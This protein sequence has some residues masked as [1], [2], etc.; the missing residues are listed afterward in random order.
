[1]SSPLAI[2]LPGQSMSFDWALETPPVDLADSL[3]LGLHLQLIAARA[4]SSD[5]SLCI[6]F[7]ARP[8]LEV[9]T[10]ETLHLL[11]DESFIGDG[12]GCR[13][14]LELAGADAE[15]FLALTER[16]QLGWTLSFDTKRAVAWISEKRPHY[17]NICAPDLVLG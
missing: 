6:E 2:P 1:M 13:R 17:I 9:A 3:P 10:A 8:V 12:P 7:D 14:V 16:R 4:V 11:A 5:G 15:M